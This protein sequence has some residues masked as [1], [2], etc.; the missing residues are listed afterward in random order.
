M[1]ALLEW[2]R[3]L[4]RSVSEQSLVVID[5]LLDV[6][7]WSIAEN[8]ILVSEVIAPQMERDWSRSLELE[9][10][11]LRERID[12]AFGVTTHNQQIIHVDCYIL[13]VVVTLSHPDVVLGLAWEEV[14]TS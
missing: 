8:S 1:I 2:R 4:L 9:L 12:N 3:C 14:H 7:A 13:V 6:L 11:G 10:V 5:A